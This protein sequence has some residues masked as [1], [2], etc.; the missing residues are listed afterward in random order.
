MKEFSKFYFK[1]F[2]FNNKELIAKF[3]YS[4]DNEIF[5]EEIIDFNSEL[6]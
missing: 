5:F 6:F 2:E 3:H 4:F 1:S